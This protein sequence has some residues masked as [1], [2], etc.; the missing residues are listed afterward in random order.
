[1]VGCGEKPT[2][3]P[4]RAGAPTAAPAKAPVAAVA[5]PRYRGWEDIYRT[6]WT[7]DS[8]AKG[9]HH[10]NCWYQR[11][12]NWNVYVKEGVVWREEQA[13]QYPQ[14]NSSVPDYNPRGCQK[15]GCYSR[16]MYD[17]GR[18]RYPLK[19]SGKR[20]EGKW[21]RVTWDEALNDITDRMLEVLG[22]DG[23]GAIYWDMGTAATNG[24]HGVGLF[25][26]SH[27]LDSIVLDMNSEIGDHHPGALVTCGKI[28][29]ASSA[30]DWFY[31]DLIL[32]WGG[33]PLYTQIPNAHFFNEARYHGARIVTVAPDLNASAV[34]ADLWVPVEMGS[35]A[36]LGLAMAKVIIDE[37]L[38]DEAFLREQTDMPFLVRTDTRRFLR[39]S[40]MENGGADDVFYVY[41]LNSNRISEAPKKS[42]D[43]DGVRPAL[44]GE[45]S[46]ATPRGSVRVA[47]VF[48]RL[49]DTLAKYTPEAASVV[50]GTPADLIRR[51]ARMIG[52]AKSA[53]VLT[54]SN[55][56]KYYH[57]M[58]MERV[59]FLVLA[60]CGHFGRKGSGVNGFPW[61]SVEA[62][63]PATVAPAMPFK[64]ALIALGAKAAPAWA[65]AKWQGKTTEMFL[66]EQARGEYAKGG[67]LPSPIFF[68]RYGG[69]APL[70]GSSKRWDP[71]LKRELD[72]YLSEAL[73]KGWQI[74]PK[75][76]PRIFFE[77]GGNILRRIRGYDRL[78]KGLVNNLDL[79][80][81]VDWH[82]SNTARHSDYVLPAAAW[83]ERDDITWATPIA[84]FAQVTTEAVKPL[85]ES[86]SDWVFHCLLLKRLQERAKKRGLVSFRDR[87]GQTKRLDTVYDDLTFGR[88]YTEK[89][90][91]VF[92][93]AML[94]ANGNLGG[95]GWKELKEKGAVRFTALGTSPVTIGTATD[96]KPDET[97]TAFTWHTEQKTPWPTLTRRMQFYVDHELYL[98]LGEE[99]PTHKDNPAIG[100][101][102]PLKMTGGHTR[103]SIH[104]SW[105]DTPLM[106]RL[107]RGEPAMFMNHRDAE[108]RGIT[109]GD[110][111]R[112][113]N[114]IGAFE[115]RAKVSRN[116][117]PGQVVV[118]H[119]WE[120]Y[121]FSG[122]RSHQ[123]ATPTPLNPIQLAG[124]YF[125]LQPMMIMGEPGFNDRGTRLEVEKITPKTA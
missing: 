43:L 22:E 28:C 80:V 92:L 65:K 109:D 30:D 91:Q 81:T 120:P 61:L 59:Q 13:G 113:R 60:L 56:S 36:A 4:K 74:A 116:V 72:D 15:G 21:T 103:W 52:K 106:L 68:H 29:F 62:A 17:P 38:H 12:C 58:E 37:R 78:I 20:G 90:P 85:A 8:V 1:V 57:G 110:R 9:T 69:L 95:T 35:D 104:S 118:Y 102:Y 115:I 50:T 88:R 117:Q 45:F 41:D 89:N 83:Y 23:P 77:A 10:V 64:A 97:I 16:R 5:I 40:D 34:H 82:M 125:H 75:T 46:V 70:T 96:I 33:N 51:L 25:R 112:A 122:G 19:R 124:G 6:Q 98:E 93:G 79:F 49:R 2:A 24:C 101:N 84:P 18:L 3:P 67:F 44:E 76:A 86:K 31:S 53:T 114:D 111:V 105:R 99:L 71:H 73:E 47:P 54:Q 7:W 121:Q 11:G 27:L 94:E 26:T 107:Q 42:L 63:E 48:Q 32:I 119:A 100:G 14:T 108:A 123:V 55:F 87:S 39:Q 66:Y